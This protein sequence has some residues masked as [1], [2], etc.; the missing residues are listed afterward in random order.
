VKEHEAYLRELRRRRRFIIVR[1]TRSGHVRI[2]CPH[3]LLVA[4]HSMNG[5]SDHRALKNLQAD[6]RRHACLACKQQ[7]EH[8]QGEPGSDERSPDRPWLNEPRDDTGDRE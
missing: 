2:F 3:G 4:V 8:V 1:K 7:G 6:V 5:G